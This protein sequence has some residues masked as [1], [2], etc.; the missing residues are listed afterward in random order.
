MRIHYSI[1]SPFARKVRIFAALTQQPDIEWVLTK[2]LETPSLRSINPLGKIPALE[3]NTINLF[4]S[5][6]ICEYLD[7][8]Y[9]ARGGDSLFRRGKADYF[10]VQKQHVLAN[11]IMDAAVASVMDQRRPDA[12]ASEF[13]LGRWQQSVQGGLEAVEVE[14]LG[15][16][17]HLNI[18][19]VAMVCALGYLALRI[20]T[21]EPAKLNPALGIWYADQA[22][23]PWFIATVP[24]D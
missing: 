11:G 22:Q 12:P 15:S 14:V 8:L 9:C 17:G 1:T 7:E 5:T 19:G 20:P 2:P 23:A 21:L 6:L 10:A 24:Q 4:D 16:Q 13:W 3:S 18:A